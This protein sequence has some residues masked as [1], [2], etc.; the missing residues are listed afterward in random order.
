MSKRKVSESR[1]EAVVK[2]LLEAKADVSVEDNDGWTALHIA[3]KNG[4][5]AVVKLLLASSVPSVNSAHGM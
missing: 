2:L 5:E 4:Y 3:A 1:P